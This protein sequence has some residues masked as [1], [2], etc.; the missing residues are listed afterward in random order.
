MHQ[1]RVEIQSQVIFCI[2]RL[3]PMRGR[4]VNY[5]T[6]TPEKKNGERMFET[7]HVHINNTTRQNDF[8]FAM[9]AACTCHAKSNKVLQ[10]H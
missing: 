1:N 4:N 8:F 6:T 3:T 5:R 2:L 10:M 9:L 7:F